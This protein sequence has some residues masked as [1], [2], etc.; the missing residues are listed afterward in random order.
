[1]QRLLL[2]A[3]RILGPI[4]LTRFLRRRKKPQFHNDDSDIGQREN[5]NRHD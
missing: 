1:M 4:L 3:A 2:M 5:N